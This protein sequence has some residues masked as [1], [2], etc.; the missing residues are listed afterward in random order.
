LADFTASFVLN[1]HITIKEKIMTE[2]TTENVDVVETVEEENEPIYYKP[3]TLNL[4]ATLS[5]IFGWIIL[6]GFIADVV[7][8]SLNVQ[9]QLAQQGLVLTTLLSEPSFQSYVFTNLVVPLLTGLG[10]FFALEGISIGLNVLLEI[11]FNQRE[12]KN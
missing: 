12:L 8:Q 9:A 3:K 7:F 11:D 2:Q 10:L 1:L 5:A 6:V 4:V